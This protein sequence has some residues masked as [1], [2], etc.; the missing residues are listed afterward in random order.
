[1]GRTPAAGEA[2]PLHGLTPRQFESLTHGE[3]DAD[4]LAELVRAEHSHRLLLLDVLMDALTPLAGAA[5]GPLPAPRRAWDL[6]AAAQR[7]APT[8]VR[9]LLDLPE[10]GLW[11]AQLLNRLCRPRPHEL[12][13]WAD[14]GH[15]HCLAAAAALRA[16]LD[17]SFPLPCV[18]G[19][20]ELPALGQVRLPARAAQEVAVLAA[21][22]G[23]VTVTAPHGIV[24]LPDDPS[25]PAPGWL[26]LHHAELRLPGTA[27]V[28]LAFDDLGPHRIA[29]R[30]TGAA[31]R[32]GRR[33]ATRL[34][35][36]VQGGARLVAEA[37]P[38][39]AATL[40]AL[41]RTIQPMPAYELFRV[42]SATSG[43][44]VGG[45]ALSL[46]ESE[47]AC[48]AAL[49]HELQHSKLDAFA[50]LFPLTE[51]KPGPGR[52]YYAP[53]RDDP[54]PLAGMLQ[55][56]YAFTGVA[57]FWRGRTRLPGGA[58]DQLAWL[59]FSLW[60][61][62]LAQVVPRIATDPE[63]TGAGR[64]LLDGVHA[65][66][67]GWSAEA[68]GETAAREAVRLAARLA[69]DHRA[70][71]R[72]HHVRPFPEDV[73]ALA[74]AWPTDDGTTLPDRRQ[75]VRASRRQ[76]HLDTRA[77]LARMAL[78]D[79]V[80]LDKLRDT[81]D[82]DGVPGVTGAVLADLVWATGDPATAEHHY[83]LSLT[84]APTAPAAWAGLR[85]T[86]E[87][88]GRAPSALRALTAAPEL[89]RA[90]ARHL[91]AR[92]ERQ[93]DPVELAAWVGRA[94]DAGT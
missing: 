46:P 29:P 78:A 18:A 26:P 16:G 31:R 72:L 66:V 70:L 52:L 5:T 62:Q 58:H 69:A 86:L 89:V 42:R 6:L 2:E 82:E 20:V 73:E 83:R 7:R 11:A 14:V 15:L 56:I 53:W 35:R 90:L 38:A 13:L 64:S 33:T 94:V 45:L 85:L 61:G 59:E 17:F 25:R 48:A 84:E 68:P 36:L 4:A 44:G 65:T 3:G 12:P 37:D 92:V 21:R 54:R 51:E 39:S 27:P 43:H 24:R 30:P 50:H 23:T 67:S 57:R 80:A 79:P 87:E 74:A 34:T 1:M 9:E 81:A 47:L 41:L 55:G 77:V 28:R 91:H 32:L 76:W 60:R 63:L 10:T 49:V 22:A 75:G 88:T 8:A 93:V 19:R 71:W 40:T